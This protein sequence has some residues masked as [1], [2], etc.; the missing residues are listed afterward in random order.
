MRVLWNRIYKFKYLH[1]YLYWWKVKYYQDIFIIEFAKKNTDGRQNIVRNWSFSRYE[2][3][4]GTYIYI[5][6]SIQNVAAV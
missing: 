2:F 3:V 5:Y 4:A 6:E 1:I